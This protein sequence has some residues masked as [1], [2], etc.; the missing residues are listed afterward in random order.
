M[1]GVI[2][3]VNK[4]LKEEGKKIVLSKVSI[5]FS[6]IQCISTSSCHNVTVSDFFLF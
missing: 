2:A 1:T 6:S 5:T 3:D 4:K